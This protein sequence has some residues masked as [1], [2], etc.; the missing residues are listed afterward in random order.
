MPFRRGIPP[1]AEQRPKMPGQR[2]RPVAYIIGAAGRDLQQFGPIARHRIGLQRFALDDSRIAVARFLAGPLAVDERNRPAAALQ[3][4]CRSRADH[5]GSENDRVSHGMLRYSLR[6]GLEIKKSDA[7][8]QANSDTTNA[9]ALSKAQTRLGR[10]HMDDSSSGL[11][12]Y[13]R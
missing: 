6:S 12:R 2:H 5:S 8:P 3:M 11:R 13:S 10:Q 4:H 7:L 9:S 1:V